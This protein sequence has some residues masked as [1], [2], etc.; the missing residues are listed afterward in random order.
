[1]TG[2]PRSPYEKRFI[3]LS[4]ITVHKRSPLLVGAHCAANGS[5]SS[6]GPH[7]PAR[8]RAQALDHA[9]S[10]APKPAGQRHHVNAVSTGTSDV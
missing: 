1:M 10:E 9:S 2:F 8:T 3:R 5:I 7:N 6:Q 4:G